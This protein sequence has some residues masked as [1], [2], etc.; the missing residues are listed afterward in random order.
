MKKKVSGIVLALAVAMLALPMLPIAQAV[1]GG[2]PREIYHD[3]RVLG[4]LI[5]DYDPV[6]QMQGNMK[7][8]EYTAHCAPVYILWDYDSA[9]GSPPYWGR[10]MGPATYKIS[11]KI[12]PNTMKG[13]VRLE[14]KVTLP[15]G[16]FEGDMMW[17][18]EM[19]VWDDGEGNNPYPNALQPENIKWH[20]FW[21]GTGAYEGWT[22]LQDFNRIPPWVSGSDYAGDIHLIKPVDE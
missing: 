9:A 16:T 18:G 15:G 11:Y 6:P 20:T 3:L 12:N 21:K 17:V 10:L 2:T 13:V 14:T 1:Q 8:A 19:E 22:I 4:Q 5:P 7:C